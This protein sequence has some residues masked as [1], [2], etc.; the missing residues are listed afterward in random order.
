MEKLDNLQLKSILGGKIPG[1][2]MFQVQLKLQLQV[3]GLV[4]P[5]VDQLV[6]L[7][8]H[9]M[10]LLRGL[11]LLAQRTAFTRIERNIIY[12]KIKSGSTEFNSRW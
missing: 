6:D 2:K 8:A 1:S 10:E 12:E 11:V 3:Q 5:S 7:L 4:V 9:I